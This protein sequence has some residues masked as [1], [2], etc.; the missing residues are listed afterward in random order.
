MN[1]ITFMQNG[2]FV[3]GPGVRHMIMG[4]EEDGSKPLEPPNL[5]KH[6]KWKCVYVQSRDLDRELSSGTSYLFCKNNNNSPEINHL[7]FHACVRC[8]DGQSQGDC[9]L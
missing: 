1:C 8:T 4:V 7:H 6:T 5:S 3:T 9:I 2:N